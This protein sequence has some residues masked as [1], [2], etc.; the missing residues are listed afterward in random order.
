MTT[1]AHC[2]DLASM[3]SRS[4]FSAGIVLPVAIVYVAMCIA[5][6]NVSLLDW[7]MFT[8]SFGWTGS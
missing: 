1:S 6:G 2:L 8:W 4:R 7:P 3:A 5:V